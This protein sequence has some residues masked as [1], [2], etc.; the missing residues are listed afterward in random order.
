MEI[1]FTLLRGVL[2][3]VVGILSVAIGVFVTALLWV[4]FR[5]IHIKALN[6][7]SYLVKR[8]IMKLK[9]ESKRITKLLLLIVYSGTQLYLL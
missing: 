8:K 5:Y 7:R 6:F 3:I 1:L 2:V 4:L 9:G